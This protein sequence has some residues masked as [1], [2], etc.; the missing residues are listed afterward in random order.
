ML[1]ALLIIMVILAPVCMAQI[2][3]GITMENQQNPLIK[4]TTDKGEMYL[5]MFPDVA[6]KHVESMLKLIKD[7]YY[8]DLTF[9][10][11]V[12]GFVIQGGCPKG[13]GTGGP[14]YTLPA[15]FNNRKHL[16]G[17]LAMARTSDPNSAGSQFYICLDAIPHLDNQYTVFG[18]IVKGHEV[19]EK[20]KQGDKMQIEIIQEGN[21][22]KN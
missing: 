14:G 2:P 18:Q 11:V 17:T 20:V 5:E 10:R 9:H 16:K 4:I 8:N 12:P 1:E 15:E 3:Q 19:P 22:A 13:N 7:G 21:N 6:P